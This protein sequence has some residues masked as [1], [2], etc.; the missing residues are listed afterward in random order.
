MI[1]A[2][3]SQLWLF[4]KS[5]LTSC[6]SLWISMWFERGEF[7]T[8]PSQPTQ[9]TQPTEPTV[10]P[11]ELNADILKIWIIITNRNFLN[12]SKTIVTLSWL[13]NPFMDAHHSSC[14]GPSRVTHVDSLFF[15]KCWLAFFISAVKTP[16]S[17]QPVN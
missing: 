3:N 17:Q 6:I 5:S 2:W 9:S 15:N 4:E 13:N 8:Q 7:Y 10:M 16:S 11:P 1:R 12:N 14:N